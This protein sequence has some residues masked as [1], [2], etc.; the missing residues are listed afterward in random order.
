MGFGEWRNGDGVAVLGEWVHRAGRLRSRSDLWREPVA[1][2]P[3]R[4]EV[5]G[6]LGVF[7][8]FLA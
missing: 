7:F 2:T 3:Y 8:Q 4:V 1:D 5:P 6:T